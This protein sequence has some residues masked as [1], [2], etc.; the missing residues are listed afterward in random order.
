MNQ[1]LVCRIHTKIGRGLER[2][3]P[4]FARSSRGAA[5]GARCS[6]WDPSPN[7][8]ARPPRL[9]ED[10][11]N[12][13]PLCHGPEPFAKRPIMSVTNQVPDGPIESLML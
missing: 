7:K 8:G 13:S 11:L 10:V 3:M 6:Q 4:H 2:T 12:S 9:L 1:R 5:P